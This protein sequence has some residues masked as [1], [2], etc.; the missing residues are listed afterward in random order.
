MQ[1]NVNSESVSPTYKRA[2]DGWTEP[3]KVIHT[4]IIKLNTAS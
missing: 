2:E 1:M 3:F 4:F